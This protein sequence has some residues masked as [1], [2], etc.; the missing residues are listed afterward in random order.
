M[1]I[2][3]VDER[4]NGR[5]QKRKASP[6]FSGHTRSGSGVWR[7]CAGVMRALWISFPLDLLSVQVIDPLDSL[8]SSEHNPQDFFL[9]YCLNGS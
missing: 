6:A 8:P 7:V 4:W 5:V 3:P 9:V 1:K 2:C